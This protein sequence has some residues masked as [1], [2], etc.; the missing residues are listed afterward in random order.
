MSDA[1]SI[2]V[3]GS[4]YKGDKIQ[5]AEFCHANNLPYILGNTL[6]YVMRHRKKNG[7]Q[8]LEKAKHYLQILHDLD[9]LSPVRHHAFVGQGQIPAV[10][11]ITANG[12]PPEEAEIIYACMRY[13]HDP[14]P[15]SLFTAI[16]LIEDLM[17]AAY[18]RD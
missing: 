4:H 5:H 1:L 2:Q 16:Q 17:R 9:A 6:K 11:L 14:D 7:L 13:H 8:D 3:G 12:I 18:P 10:K 15:H